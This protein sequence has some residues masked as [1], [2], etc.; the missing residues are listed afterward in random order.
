MLLNRHR[1]E[2]TTLFFIVR[3]LLRNS[4]WTSVTDTCGVYVYTC[5]GRFVLLLRILFRNNVVVRRRLAEWWTDLCLFFLGSLR[6]VFTPAVRSL[7]RDSCTELLSSIRLI[8]TTHG[9][10]LAE[11]H[12]GLGHIN[13]V[14]NIQGGEKN[15][16]I[17]SHCKYSENSMTELLGNWS[18]TA[19]WNF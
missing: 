14:K 9:N 17:P 18:A 2:W 19:R 13:E 16:A 4:W 11:W 6:R 12:S 3:I 10:G 5:L 1:L 15:G 8:N 7:S